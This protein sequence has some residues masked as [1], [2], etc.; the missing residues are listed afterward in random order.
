M[1]FYRLE[2]DSF[3]TAIWNAQPPRFKR[4]KPRKGPLTLFPISGVKFWSGK[5]KGG[6]GK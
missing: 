1:I 3:Q 5:M 2:F 6:S 4:D